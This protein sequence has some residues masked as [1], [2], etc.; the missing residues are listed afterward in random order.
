MDV[1]DAEILGDEKDDEFAALYSLEK[2][3]EPIETPL[4]TLKYVFVETKNNDYHPP[5]VLQEAL[6]FCRRPNADD[7]KCFL[8]S[9]RSVDHSPVN[10]ALLVDYR[11]TDCARCHK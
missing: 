11:H 6:R 10:D 2:V 5:E 1:N 9:E 7:P 4:P 8:L 3:S